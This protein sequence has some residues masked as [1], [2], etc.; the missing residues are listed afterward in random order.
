MRIPKI[1]ESTAVDMT[2]HAI[3]YRPD[4]SSV[5]TMVAYATSNVFS[6]V[7]TTKS[8]SSADPTSLNPSR[9]SSRSPCPPNSWTPRMAKMISRSAQ[10]TRNTHIA[11]TPLMALS[12]MRTN[13]LFSRSTRNVRT[14]RKMRKTRRNER[15]T[16]D[17]LCDASIMMSSTMDDTTMNPSSLFQESPQYPP[18][19]SA[20]CFRENS[21]M[22][23]IVNAFS[24]CLVA[25]RYH[26]AGS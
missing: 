5:A 25:S 3:M 22:N 17:P 26:S 21:T 9:S 4:H 20:R 13:S 8:V 12:R 19:P 11:C 23:T 24:A 10:T 2:S 16:P 18:N 7:D 15:F 14:M 6:P 1:S